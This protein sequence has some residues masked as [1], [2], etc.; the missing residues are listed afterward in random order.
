MKAWPLEPLSSLRSAQALRAA[1]GVALRW[2]EASRARGEAE[3][4]ATRAEEER[5]RA[6]A[7]A[8][9]PDAAPAGELA[10][11]AASR[12]ALDRGARR[13]AREGLLATQRAERAGRR[14]EEATVAL[15]EIEGRAGALSRGAARWAERGRGSREAAREREI[16]EAW[17]GRGSRAGGATAFTT[18]SVITSPPFDWRTGTEH[19]GDEIRG[20]GNGFS[21]RRDRVPARCAP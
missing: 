5:S 4:M 10:R 19:T 17:G 13:M 7:C 8:I 21:R 18:A 14:A 16:E 20:G 3:G 12:A 11:G 2:A 9:A 15:R 6:V 1:R